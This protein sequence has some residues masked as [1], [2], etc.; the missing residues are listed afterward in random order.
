M[1]EEIEIN[2][3]ANTNSSQHQNPPL[4]QVQRLQTSVSQSGYSTVV[5]DTMRTYLL[6]QEDPSQQYAL[7]CRSDT[8][9]LSTQRQR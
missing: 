8:D 9:Q 4:Q 5:S 1:R 6:S 2:P 3:T 7:F